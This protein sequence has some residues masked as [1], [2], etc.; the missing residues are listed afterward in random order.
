MIGEDAIHPSSGNICHRC[1]AGTSAITQSR[2]IGNYD[3][4]LRAILHAFKYDGCRSLAVRL[5]DQLSYTA[6]DVLSRADVVVPVPLHFRKERMRG[7]NQARALADELDLPL[8]DVLR[9]TR[10]T[11]SQTGLSASERRANVA[12]AFALR[13]NTDAAGLRVVL[14]DDVSTTGATM[15]AC[16][17][18][19]RSAGAA[20]V[21]AVTAAR[22]V[23]RPPE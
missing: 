17:E 7:F 19:L 9:R 20:D 10:H 13:R 1:A 15:E 11:P 21:S 5:A 6:G 23:S 16:A 14:V 3:G 4:S 8:L 12:G 2:A 22:V 18:V